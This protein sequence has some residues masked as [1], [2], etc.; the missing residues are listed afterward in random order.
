MNLQPTR[1]GNLRCRILGRLT[2]LLLHSMLLA[3]QQRTERCSNLRGV[4]VRPDAV[5]V[6]TFL[7]W[8][9][10]RQSVLEALHVINDEVSDGQW[11][12]YSSRPLPYGRS[13]ECT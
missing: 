8:R 4:H 3:W 9:E 10:R 11:R 1:N 5:Q 7:G 13:H 6:I 2:L 12:R